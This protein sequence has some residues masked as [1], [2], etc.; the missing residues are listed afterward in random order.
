MIVARSKSMIILVSVFSQEEQKSFGCV[1][2]SSE[3]L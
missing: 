1:A 3:E 2:P